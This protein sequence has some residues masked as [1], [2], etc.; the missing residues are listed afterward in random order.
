MTR[1]MARLVKYQALTVELITS[2]EL[3]RFGLTSETLPPYVD[4]IVQA[5]SDGY[6]KGLKV[7]AR[8]AKKAAAKTHHKKTEAPTLKKAHAKAKHHPKKATKSQKKY[9]KPIVTKETKPASERPKMP[10]AIAKVMKPGESIG[11]HEVISRL[12][13]NGWLPTSKN[14]VAYINEIF[15]SSHRSNGPFVR[16]GPA[17]Y[18]LREPKKAESKGKVVQLRPPTKA[19]TEAPVDKALNGTSHA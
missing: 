13:K 18:S 3:R 14:L 10:I 19:K 2:P 11:F 5:G 17:K 7:G 9:G 1:F 16:T 12:R 15:S 4:I 8:S 6:D